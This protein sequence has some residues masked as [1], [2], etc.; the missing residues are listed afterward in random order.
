MQAVVF[1]L[2]GDHVVEIK[3]QVLKTEYLSA[4][5]NAVLNVFMV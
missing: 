3:E 2:E 5:R 4:S 1:I